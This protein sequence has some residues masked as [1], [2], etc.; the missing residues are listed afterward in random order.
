MSTNGIAFSSSIR[1]SGVER[2]A[3]TPAVRITLFR[4]DSILVIRT[5]EVMVGVEATALPVPVPL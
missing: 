2:V 4:V 5:P 3:A 1:T